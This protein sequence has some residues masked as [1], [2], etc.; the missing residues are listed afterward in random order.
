VKNAKVSVM[1][2]IKD[3]IQ[4]FNN[5]SL[6]HSGKLCHENLTKQ[7]KYAF[8]RPLFENMEPIIDSEKHVIAVPFELILNRD[9]I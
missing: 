7:A 4:S 3:V 5:P 9:F 8:L 2:F 1:V 6:A